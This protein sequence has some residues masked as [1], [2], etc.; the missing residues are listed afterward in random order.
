MKTCP[1]CAE[2]IQD[3][4]LLCPH[5]R[6]RVRYSPPELVLLAMLALLGTLW[7]FGDQIGGW[8]D[9]MTAKQN[10]PAEVEQILREGREHERQIRER[11]E[12]SAAKARAEQ[13]G[14]EEEA[15]RKAADGPYRVTVR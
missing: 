14:R 2:Q 4:A 5:C 15:R 10:S 11:M 1:T 12:Q 13:A 8:L 3:A 7:L 6:S 9:R